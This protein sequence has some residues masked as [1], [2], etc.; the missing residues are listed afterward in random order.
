ML[1]APLAAQDEAQELPWKPQDRWVWV[2]TDDEK[3]EMTFVAL[4]RVVRAGSAAKVETLRVHRDIDERFG[5]DQAHYHMLV[6]CDDMSWTRLSFRGY[7]P[8]GSSGPLLTRDIG[9][10]EAPADGSMLGR[11]FTL[12]CGGESDSAAVVASPYEHAKQAMA[13]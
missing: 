10:R 12:A 4:A 9:P 13:D 11:A 1:A 7:R 3:G 8:D 6:D 5:T 2:G